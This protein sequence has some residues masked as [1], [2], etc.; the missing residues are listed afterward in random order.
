MCVCCPVG[1]LLMDLGKK[2]KNSKWESH[3]HSIVKLHVP[4]VFVSVWMTVDVFN[5]VSLLDL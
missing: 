1:V 5:Y 3:K 2:Q 4:L